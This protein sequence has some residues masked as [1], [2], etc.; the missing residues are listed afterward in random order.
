MGLSIDEFDS[1]TKSSRPSLE[2]HVRM[3]PSRSPTNS[4]VTEGGLRWQFQFVQVDSNGQRQFIRVSTST[5]SCGE[6][7]G[8]GGVVEI[9][10]EVTIAFDYFRIP[11]FTQYINI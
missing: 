11:V 4:K 10:C 3:G 1:N 8:G 9:K 7:G 6:G 2:R 5:S